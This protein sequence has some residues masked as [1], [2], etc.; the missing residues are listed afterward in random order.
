MLLGL[1]IEVPQL[2]WP[3]TDQDE[4]RQQAISRLRLKR[5]YRRQVRQYLIVN[6]GLVVIWL[7]SGMGY[8]W[9]VWPIFGWGMAL[10][11]HGWKLTHPEKPFSDEEISLEMDQG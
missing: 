5:S 3:V 8:F 2:C 1:M 11:I 7:I 9:P 4:L 6:T 10:L